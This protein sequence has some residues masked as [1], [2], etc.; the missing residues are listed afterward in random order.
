MTTAIDVRIHI[1]TA[2]RLSQID[3]CALKDILSALSA[4]KLCCKEEFVVF[5]AYNVRHTNDVQN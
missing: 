2:F 4:A 5:A 3:K 1:S